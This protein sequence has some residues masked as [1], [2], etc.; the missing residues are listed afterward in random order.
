M[1]IDPITKLSKTIQR[2]D[3]SLVRITATAMFGEGLHQ[4]VDVYVHKK[5][6]LDADWILCNDRPHPDW[7][8]MSREDYINHGRSEKFQAV[9]H[10]E[11]L[12]VSTM[13]GK[14]M[15]TLQ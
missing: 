10:G 9:S 13:I 11:I 1:V 12:G 5:P 7:K 14:P 6:T 8:S 4:S 2:T 15:S 3:G